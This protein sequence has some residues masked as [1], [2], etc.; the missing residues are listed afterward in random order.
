[1]P[2][3]IGNSPANL[4]GKTVHVDLAY[5][6][7]PG[8]ASVID[9]DVDDNETFTIGD[10]TLLTKTAWLINIDYGVGVALAFIDD[11]GDAVVILEVGTSTSKFTATVDTTNA[12]YMFGISSGSLVYK[13]TDGADQH[14]Q[15]TRLT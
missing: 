13:N 15:I 10:P 8:I 9:I 12:Q 2:T 14:V 4:V 11:D 3:P 6:M 7:D 5:V 1:M